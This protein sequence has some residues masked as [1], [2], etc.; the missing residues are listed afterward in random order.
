M[1]VAPA[2]AMM[3]SDQ[4]LPNNPGHPAIEATEHGVDKSLDHPAISTTQMI[5]VEKTTSLFL[6]LP[7]ELQTEAVNYLSHNSDLKTLR[8][9][10]KHVSDIVT[11][12]FYYKVDL[13]YTG[14]CN[15]VM[16]RIESLLIQP[17]NLRFVRILVTP[18]LGSEETQ[19]LDR[20]L[21]LLQRDSLTQ[22]RFSTVSADHFPT[23]RQMQFMWT[24]QKKIKYVKLYSYMVPVFEELLKKHEP[25]RIAWLKSVTDLHI[26]DCGYKWGKNIQS[27]ICWPLKNLDL[28][29]LRM[30]QI[31]KLADDYFMSTLNTLF[32]RGSFVN[33]LILSFQYITAKE[34]LTLTNLPLLKSLVLYVNGP[35]QTSLPLILTDDIKLSS[36]KGCTY[37]DIEKLTFLLTQTKGLESLSIEQSEEIRTIGQTQKDLASAIIRHQQTLRVLNL[38]LALALENALDAWMWDFHFVQAMKSCKK[39]VD[40][41]LPLD[42]GKPTCYYLSLIKSLP[43]LVNLTIYNHFASY[44]DWIGDPIRQLFAAAEQLKSISIKARYT[45]FGMRDIEFILKRR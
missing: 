9:V 18:L 31:G 37:R 32:A 26:I 10:S 16:Q 40:L 4:S 21:P 13:D 3:E 45:D 15:R 44:H 14:T 1:K 11:P 29:G 34:K 2:V 20:V 42:S 33:L 6:S 5:T 30:M 19:L 22:F 36:F 7:V 25:S 12:R 39:L 23:A 28:S 41:S 8:L 27:M 17:V 35:S 38:K 24:N 43:D